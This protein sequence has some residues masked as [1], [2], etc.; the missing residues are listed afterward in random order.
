MIEASATD[1]VFATEWSADQIAAGHVTVV[2]D[3]SL[4]LRQLADRRIKNRVPSPIKKEVA[5]QTPWV[6][7]FYISVKLS[8]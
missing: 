1:P 4:V 7:C 3:V 2:D 6:F 8:S 5:V